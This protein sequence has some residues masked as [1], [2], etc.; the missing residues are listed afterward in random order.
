MQM[1]V[2][3]VMAARRTERPSGRGRM[4]A[5]GAHTYSAKVPVH[6]GVPKS[7]LEAQRLVCPSLHQQ[8]SPQ[9]TSASTT[10]GWPG[11]NL[12]TSLPT[13]STTPLPSWPVISGGMRRA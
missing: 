2:G 6:L 12:V 7:T 9:P 13:A 11:L 5:S 3:S 1:A 10:Q 4:L 8:H